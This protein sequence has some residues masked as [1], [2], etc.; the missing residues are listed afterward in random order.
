VGTALYLR[1]PEQLISNT[2]QAKDYLTVNQAHAYPQ[3][4]SSDIKAN[5]YHHI[6]FPIAAGVMLI[7]LLYLKKT[8]QIL[9]KDNFLWLSTLFFLLF[10]FFNFQRGLVR[11]SLSEGSDSFTSSFFYLSAGLFVVLL[12]SQKMM[13]FKVAVFLVFITASRYVTRYPDLIDVQ[14]LFSQMENSYKNVDKIEKLPA[15]TMRVLDADAFADKNYNDLKHFFD[16]NFDKDNTFIDFSNTPMLYFYLQREVPSYFC[17]YMQ[18]TTTEFLQEENLKL[19]QKKNVPI[20]LFSNYPNTWFDYTDGVPNTL[21][22]N[23]I[24]KYIYD[25]YVPY[26]V[27]NKHTVW[28]KKGITLNNPVKDTS[29]S[30]AYEPQNYKLIKYPYLLGKHG[31]FP[32]E[33]YNFTKIH[34]HEKLPVPHGIA[35]KSSWIYLKINDLAHDSKAKLSYYKDNALMGSM[36]FD[37][38]FGEENQ[39]YVLPVNAQY[40][41]YSGLA[42]EILIN[43]TNASSDVTIDISFFQQ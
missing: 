38:F 31:N 32:I 37:V 41:W 39:R 3:I 14:D 34:N 6:L 42:D 10:Y 33:K 17:Q 22:Y 12:L 29:L 5:F 27:L 4:E 20:A 19:L 21:R 43:L 16:V 30:F 35:C 9:T 25:N 24:C 36:E 1:S 13:R 23:I 8:K 15:K 18:N 40:N 2:L 7:L 28:I 11:H 26:T